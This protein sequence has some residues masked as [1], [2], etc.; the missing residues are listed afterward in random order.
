[1][2]GVTRGRAAKWVL[3]CL[4]VLLMPGMVAAFFAQVSSFMGLTVQGPVPDISSVMEDL[5][6]FSRQV[7]FLLLVGGSLGLVLAF[8][9]DE[10]PRLGTVAWYVH[11][12]GHELVHAVI[13][14]LCGYQIR[15]FKFTK[16]GGY[17]AYAK[18]NARGN[19]LI[20]LGPYLFPLIPVILVLLAALIGGVA[21]QVVFF[22]LGAAL[23][24]HLAGTT[25]E[26]ADQYDVRQAGLFFSVM[27]I[28]LANIWLVVVV[29]AVV[30][31]SRVSVPVFAE[32]SLRLN[33]WY[34]TSL[35]GAIVGLFRS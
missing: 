30:A 17:V 22:L 7:G 8:K 27:L 5:F 15:E 29:M 3:A 12:V 20:S 4:I 26:A 31:P 9:A 33:Y 23:G 34:L 21:Q 25:R 32:S 2:R 14:R 10:I 16:Q 1:M 35:L 19:F 28:A 24:S 18:P 11:L 6:A 13:A